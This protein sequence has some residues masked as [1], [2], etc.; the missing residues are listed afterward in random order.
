V[1][2]HLT[3]NALHAGSAL[4]AALTHGFTG[5]FV[6]SAILIA[7]GGVVAIVRLPGRGHKRPHEHV[8]ALALS[9]GRFPGAP[10]LGHHARL[11]ALRRRLRGSLARS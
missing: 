4:H 10:H 8:E 6:V 11:V 5:V 9:F 3:T 7:V 2:A 1:A